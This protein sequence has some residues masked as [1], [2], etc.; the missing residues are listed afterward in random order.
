LLSHPVNLGQSGSPVLTLDSR[1]VVGLVEGRWLRSSAVSLARSS[2]QRSET[3]GAAIPI[4]Y[5][6]AL[7]QRESILWHAPGSQSPSSASPAR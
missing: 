5:A 3:P 6:I 4:C 2:P 1:A 7:I